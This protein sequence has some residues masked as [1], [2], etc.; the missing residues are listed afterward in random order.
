M[1]EAG[2]RKSSKDLFFSSSSKIV[3]MFTT[4]RPNNQFESVDGK[5]CFD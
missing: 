5:N 3:D 2:S 1:R 4:L